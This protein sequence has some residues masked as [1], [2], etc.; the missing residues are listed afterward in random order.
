MFYLKTA[1]G[2]DTVPAERRVYF[3]GLR[4][5]RIIEDGK[6]RDRAAPKD[7]ATIKAVTDQARR[8][9]E[10]FVRSIGL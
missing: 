1:E 10:I 2:D 3:S 5:I 6:T 9:K 8:M 7:A 4:M